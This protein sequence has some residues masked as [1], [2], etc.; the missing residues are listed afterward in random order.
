MFDHVD[1]EPALVAF[2]GPSHR[3][4]AALIAAA[5]ARFGRLVEA[6][7]D[8]SE[9]VLGT[10]F[11]NA[12]SESGRR[13]AVRALFQLQREMEGEA[14]EARRARVVLTSGGTPE[15]LAHWPGDPRDYWL[16][17]SSDRAEELARYSLV[18]HAR[19]ATRADG[20]PL[21]WSETT[22]VT[23]GLDARLDVAW[24]GHPDRLVLSG[25]IR[26]EQQ[27][28]AV[29]ARLEAEVLACTPNRLRLLARADL[30]A[31]PVRRAS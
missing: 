2:T 9:A 23:A 22:L 30:R 15:W 6:L 27:L 12:R 26:L 21:D 10:C 19:T 31:L 3:A 29:F 13:C 16:E 1:H 7:P 17:V 20:S 18:I 11:P 14:I 28:A 8:A 24:S 25:A 5:Q 4:R